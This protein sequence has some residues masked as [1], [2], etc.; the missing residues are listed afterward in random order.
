M[1]FKSLLNLYMFIII[2]K[3]GE[4]SPSTAVDLFASLYEFISLL[5][6]LFRQQLFIPS[7]LLHGSLWLIRDTFRHCELTI[8][9]ERWLG[10]SLFS[11]HPSFKCVAFLKCMVHVGLL[12]IH[13]TG[14]PSHS[15]LCCKT[16]RNNKRQHW[17]TAAPFWPQR[18][19]LRD[20]SL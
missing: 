6:C 16:Q 10:H 1:L 13:A 5:Y 4:H 8:M 18:T 17:L 20:I 3:L 7:T 15:H 9:Q 19:R 11:W 14:A 2:V 12:I